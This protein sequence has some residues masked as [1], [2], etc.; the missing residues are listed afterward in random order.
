MSAPAHRVPRTGDGPPVRLT[1]V[2]RRALIDL[3]E[4]GV[5]EDAL[6]ELVSP[7]AMRLLQETADHQYPN[8]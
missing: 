6:A 1:D 4:S 2:Q 8:G 5:P 3:R 7:D